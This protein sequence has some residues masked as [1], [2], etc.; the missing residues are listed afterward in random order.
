[1][2]LQNFNYMLC[3]CTYDISIVL[4]S[5]SNLIKMFRSIHF[6]QFY[7]SVESLVHLNIFFISQL[8]FFMYPVFFQDNELKQTETMPD[9]PL[10]G[11]S[12]DNIAVFNGNCKNKK[13]WGHRHSI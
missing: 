11:S 5:Q 10:S 4:V 12:S 9:V 2:E 8:L 1:M 7:N 3:H 6:K 13:F